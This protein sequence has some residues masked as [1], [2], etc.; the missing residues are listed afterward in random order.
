M[1]SRVR[2]GKASLMPRCGLANI[3]SFRL[4]LILPYT[5]QLSSTAVSPDQNR[6]PRP[7]ARATL[8][9]E[10]QPGSGY[11]HSLATGPSSDMVSYRVCLSV[12]Y[13]KPV[14]IILKIQ[15]FTAQWSLYVQPVQ[16]S[17]FYVLPAQCAMYLPNLRYCPTP[18][19]RR[20]K[21]NSPSWYQ[22][23][24]V[25]HTSWALGGRS[26]QCALLTL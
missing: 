19:L 15:P 2:G 7:H 3:I 8:V 10:L 16:H 20:K 13:V 5:K 14:I 12:F 9:T 4:R 21:C 17:Q 18:D 1:A 23:A 11:C 26:Q 24:S 25:I 22:L 6:R